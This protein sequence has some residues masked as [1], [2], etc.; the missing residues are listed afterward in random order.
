VSRAP[1]GR[2]L[3]PG[4]ELVRPQRVGDLIHALLQRSRAPVELVAHAIAENAWL[5][6]RI[7]VI[8]RAWWRSSEALRTL[9]DGVRILRIASADR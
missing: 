3:A 8:S 9:A 2:L 6:D 5:I 7:S 4:L 1:V